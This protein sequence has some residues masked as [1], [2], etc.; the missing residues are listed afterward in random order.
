MIYNKFQYNNHVHTTTQNVPLLQDTSQ[1]P[2]MG[3]EPNQQ[4]SHV[5]LINKFKEQMEHALKEAKAALVKSKDDMA[6][7][8]DQK[9]TP[10]PEYRP[11]DKVY[12]DASDIHTI[13]PSVIYHFR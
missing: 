1:I 9:W 7:Y 10:A 13:R 11:G 2:C 4:W 8:Y 12:L 3:F 5:E 6:R